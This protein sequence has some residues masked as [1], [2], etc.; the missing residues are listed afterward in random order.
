[1]SCGCND[2]GV[3]YYTPNAC[4]P[5][6]TNTAACETLPSA[7]D[8]FISHF[9]GTVTK[10]EVNGRVTWTLP[11]N[12]DVGLAANARLAG[13][14]LACYFLRLFNEGIVGLKGDQGDVG[15]SGY[16]GNNAYAMASTQ[17]SIPAINGTT[18]FDIIPTP[19]VTTGMIIFLPG[20][21]WFEVTNVFQGKTIFAT[22]RQAVDSPAAL[23]P[24][25]TLVIPAGYRGESVK[26]D[27]G[28]TGAK[29]DKGDTGATGATGA[30]GPTGATG[31]AGAAATNTNAQDT[32]GTTDHTL[33]VGYA[34][35]DFG[36]D[37]LEVTLLAAGTY[38]LMADLEITV[39]GLSNTDAGQFKLY[40]STQGADVA[41]SEIN[42]SIISAR[43]V[44][45]NLKAIATV[46]ANDVIQV[47]GQN[48]DAARGDVKYAN[49]KLIYI[50]LA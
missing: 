26:G 36:T 28:D 14:G 42:F 20:A 13:E 3:Q 27:T 45:V 25:A 35:I 8:N 44:Q 33:T 46:A 48:I 31:A 15:P 32:G 6:P 29:G 18:Q 23:L 38:L 41:G 19:V 21:G 30:T 4:A 50:K 9:F 49:S 22:F 12:L 5:C 40:N 1:M 16:D 24:P 10:T 37:D 11:C 17:I 2:S 7:L 39:G 34:K 43:T 47:W